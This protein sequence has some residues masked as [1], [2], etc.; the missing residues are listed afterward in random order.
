MVG[1]EGSLFAR[2]RGNLDKVK[3]WQVGA[4]YGDVEH[5]ILRSKNPNSYGAKIG[6]G[7]EGISGKAQVAADLGNKVHAQY[8]VQGRA[9]AG[10]LKDGNLPEVAQAVNVRYE[11]E[12][13]SVVFGRLEKTVDKPA[14]LR[15]GYTVRN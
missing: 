11:K 7:S 13:G 8:E 15:V 14:T 3:E 2:T 9:N 5:S 6:Y 4:K 10:D 1:D 12:P